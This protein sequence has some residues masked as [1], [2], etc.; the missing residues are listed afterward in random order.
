MRLNIQS[1]FIKTPGLVNYWSFNSHIKD[2]IGGAH[3]FNGRYTG[4]T[5]DRFGRPLSA[6][7]L[8]G[9]FYQ[10]PPGNYFPTGQFTITVW[11]N[12]RNYGN[13]PS[14][15][16][17]A[18]GFHF[19]TIFCGFQGTSSRPA[20]EIFNGDNKLT[21]SFSASI[22]L[23]EWIHLAL[24]FD[25]NFHHR[26]YV[27]ANLMRSS[28]LLQ[29]LKK[30]TRLYNYIGRSDNYPDQQPYLNAIID[31]LKIFSRALSQQEI[32]FEMN[33]DI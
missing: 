5:T 29:S 22:G 17:F 1:G 6:L 14:I 32:Q 24:T 21:T 18:N 3:L 20:L 15:I 33:N 11:I 26:I 28:N 16:T 13:W 12:L 31:E 2:V 25:P 19:D 27:D 7:N 4:L 23:N 30:T 9:G 8:N 10:I